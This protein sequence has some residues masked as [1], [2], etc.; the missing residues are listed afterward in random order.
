MRFDG[1]ECE[2]LGDLSRRHRTFHVLF[3]GEDEDGG[4]L[5]VL[6]VTTATTTDQIRH[7]SLWKLRHVPQ[8]R[9]ELPQ[10]E[11]TN[12]CQRAESHA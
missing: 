1:V 6:H 11:H 10:Q 4:T 7:I 2:A 3:V 8:S 9:Y 12:T 5:Q